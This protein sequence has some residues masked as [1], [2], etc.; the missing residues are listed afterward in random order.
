MVALFDVDS[1]RY[2]EL[3]SS[4]T[5]SLCDTCMPFTFVWPCM[6]PVGVWY[7]EAEEARD[8]WRDWFRLDAVLAAIAGLALLATWLPFC[9]LRRL[10]LPFSDLIFASR[11]SCGVV[12]LIRFGAGGGGES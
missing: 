8:V 6:S 2:G 10:P 3:T 12:D 11:P 4:N 7:D 9:W 5:V 1:A